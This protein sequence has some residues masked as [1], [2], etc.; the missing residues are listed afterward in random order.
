[1]KKS[2]ALGALT[3]SG[4]LA[5]L[6]AHAE[7]T[8]LGKY[9]YNFFDGGYSS[10]VVVGDS[11]VMVVDPAWNARAEAL[12][13]D[14]ATL[15]DKPVS[16]VVL[17]H[18]H[19]D[20]VGGTEVFDGAEIVC[21]QGCQ[22]IFEL[23]V[24]NLAPKQVTL[25]FEDKLDIDLGG[26]NAQVRYLGAADGVATSVIYVPADKVAASADLYLPKAL[27][28]RKWIDDKN[29]LGT[30]KVLNEMASWD[31][32][33]TVTSHSAD[34]SLSGL[35]ENRDYYNDLYSAVKVELDAAMAKGGIGAAF[36]LIGGP[37]SEKV[38]LPAYENWS[39]YQQ[40]FPKHIER[41]AMSI[42]HG[43]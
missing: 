41:M 14:I 30:R 2:L 12:K 19:Y 10:L 43:G 11:S 34:T 7:L 3:L 15:T 31:L 16:H 28:N 36:G 37:L 24:M 33:H 22:P 42:L 6:S 20:H 27:T 40:H 39:G 4:A 8:P 35:Y 21:Q 5:T 18:E 23:D 32:Q 25:T 26:V 38:K 17:T 29:Y 9:S 13:A 1:M